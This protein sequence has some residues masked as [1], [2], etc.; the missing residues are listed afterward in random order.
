MSQL[1]ECK[2]PQGIPPPPKGFYLND[3]LKRLGQD[4]RAIETWGGG[5]GYLEQ[6][7]RVA[8]AFTPELAIL[9]I[10]PA[11]LL[12]LGATIGW[13]LRGFTKHDAQSL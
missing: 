13:V 4:G 5:D 12:F 2:S 11:C 8:T 10:P 3:C 6:A 7:F 1:G 9:L